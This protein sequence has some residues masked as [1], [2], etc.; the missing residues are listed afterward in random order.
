MTEAK[1]PGVRLL[2]LF[3]TPK[4][5]DR[6]VSLYQQGHIPVRY[7]I[8]AQ[9]TAS[10]EMMDVLG[11]GSIDRVAV[12][13]LVPAALTDFLLRKLKLELHL[14]TANS[15]IAITIPI[16][17]ASSMAL[18]MS[19]AI[20]PEYMSTDRKEERIQ[21][22]EI[23]YS[24]IAVN[25]NQ[26]YSEEVMQAARSAGAT[27]GTV[28]HGRAVPDEATVRFWNL[29]INEEKETVL[30]I[31]DHAHRRPIMEAVSSQCGYHSP[32][33]GVVLSLPVEDLVGLGSKTPRPAAPEE[34]VPPEAAE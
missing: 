14:G 22:S 5:A 24:L 7:R 23:N 29:S 1:R 2:A 9:G 26:G 4:L 6:A 11:L 34:A 25:V 20:L 18:R 13:T 3:T 19:D 10:S 28:I 30:I 12:I 21:M 17:S 27:G 31:T 32:A 15:G 8:N 16:S 33:A